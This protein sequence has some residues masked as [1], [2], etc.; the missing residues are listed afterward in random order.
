MVI[1][2][3]G[4]GIEFLLRE[5]SRGTQDLVARVAAGRNQHDDDATVGNEPHAGVFQ[6]RFAQG[7]RNDDAETPGNF[8]QNMPGAFGELGRAAS[9]RPFLD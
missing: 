2:K 1:Q 4:G 5:E 6:N 8:G 3:I 9:R 7:R